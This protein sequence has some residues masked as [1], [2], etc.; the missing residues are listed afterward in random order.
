MGMHIEWKVGN[1]EVGS[2]VAFTVALLDGSPIGS[3][4]SPHCCTDVAPRAGGKAPA[5]IEVVLLK[6]AAGR[7]A[8][9]EFGRKMPLIWGAARGSGSVRDTHRQ[10]SCLREPAA[11]EAGELY[12][13]D[14]VYSLVHRQLVMFGPTRKP[15]GGL[16]CEWDGNPQTSKTARKVCHPSRV[17]DE[18]QRAWIWSRPP[19]GSWV[20]NRKGYRP[21]PPN[22]S[23]DP[24]EPR[25]VIFQCVFPA[26][27]RRGEVV[28][29]ATLIEDGQSSH[30]L[31]TCFPPEDIRRLIMGE[32]GQESGQND[33]E[34]GMEGD[35]RG[36]SRRT[37]AG[38]MESAN[39]SHGESEGGG[40]NT[41]SGEG[42]TLRVFDEGRAVSVAEVALRLCPFMVS[43]V[44][45][46]EHELSICAIFRDQAPYLAEWVEYHL[47]AGVDHFYLYNH[48]SADD[49]VK[50]L[51]PYVRAG[52]LDLHQWDIPGHPQKEAF[53]HC[54]H[55]Y[56]HES[57]WMAMIDVDEFLLAGDGLTRDVKEVVRHFDFEGQ[58]LYV[59]EM[60]YGHQVFVSEPSK[61]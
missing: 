51:A 22:A 16:Y 25:S 57:E 35:G 54:T 4:W 48:K 52:V 61:R 30:N 26:N 17:A 19:D 31:A 7:W 29:N 47:L 28:S 2:D 6:M 11:S 53:L 34:R 58:L 49:A 40:G 15:L 42:F 27:S 13:T 21:R 5:E 33:G 41:W 9:T 39:R 43:G 24:T 38:K 32:E 14:V 1:C 18:L 50:E 20:T 12:V 56:G 59:Q 8:R 36:D 45:R 3:C 23:A 10:Q 44:K 37:G 60:F 46:L 55:K